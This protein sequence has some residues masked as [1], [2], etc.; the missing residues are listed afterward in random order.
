[1]LPIMVTAKALIHAITHWPATIIIAHF[2]PSSL[3]IDAT[4]ATHGV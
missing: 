3:F 2:T 1:M 4:A